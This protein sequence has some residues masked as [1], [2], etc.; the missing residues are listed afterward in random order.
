MPSQKIGTIRMERSRAIQ[1][2]KDMRKTNRALTK[3]IEELEMQVPRWTPVSEEL[4][5]VDQEVLVHVPRCAM[6][7]VQIDMWSEHFE[8]PV[9]WSSITQ[10]I[11]FMWN[12]NEL[13]DVTHWMRMPPPPKG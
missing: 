6:D 11:G 5:P 1:G 12:D 3:R 13:E 2:Q 4:P 10:S 7:P 8:A 9:G